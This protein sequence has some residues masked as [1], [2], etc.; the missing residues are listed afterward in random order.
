MILTKIPFL[1]VIMAEKKS[2]IITSGYTSNWAHFLERWKSEPYASRVWGIEDRKVKIVALPAHPP[3]DWSFVPNRMM[4]SL[5]MLSQFLSSSAFF[6]CRLLNAATWE[7]EMFFLRSPVSSA[8]ELDEAAGRGVR[9]CTCQRQSAESPVRVN[10]GFE[11]YMK[12]ARTCRPL[13][14]GGEMITGRGKKI[15]KIKIKRKY[16]IAH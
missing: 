6:V 7:R 12:P 4:T 2:H 1:S 5:V 9:V 15:K 13:R 8:D 3:A 14:D 11:V 16:Y 10:K